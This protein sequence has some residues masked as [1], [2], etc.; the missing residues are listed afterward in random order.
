VQL[1][2]FQRHGAV[3]ALGAFPTA[4]PALVERGNELEHERFPC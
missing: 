4:E 2:D 3:C 1:D